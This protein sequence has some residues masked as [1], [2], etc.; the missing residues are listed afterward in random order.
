MDCKRKQNI[1]K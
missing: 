1:N